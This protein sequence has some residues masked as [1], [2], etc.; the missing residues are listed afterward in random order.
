MLVGQLARHRRHCWAG[1]LLVHAAECYTFPQ[2]D[3]RSS[4]AEKGLMSMKKATLLYIASALF[5][6]A[7]VVNTFRNNDLGTGVVWFALAVTFFA[8]ARRELKTPK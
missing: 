8:L 3:W 5:V 7:A 4:A 6:V 1:A 2:R